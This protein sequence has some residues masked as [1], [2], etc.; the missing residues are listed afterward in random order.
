MNT[1][2]LV[3]SDLPRDRA[4]PHVRADCP[5]EA[6][7]PVDDVTQGDALTVAVYVLK[8]VNHGLEESV[9]VA[10]QV[11]AR[12]YMVYGSRGANQ[13]E[14]AE[15]DGGSLGQLRDG[16]DRLRPPSPVSPHGHRMFRRARQRPDRSYPV[17]DGVLLRLGNLGTVG[18]REVQGESSWILQ[19]GRPHLTEC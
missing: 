12:L 11:S 3:P 4:A 17:S 10:D 13:R 2:D 15:P 1:P 14:R 16:C 18:D 7:L 9:P 8:T 6:G 19:R 5:A